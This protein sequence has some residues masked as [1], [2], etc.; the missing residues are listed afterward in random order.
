METPFFEDPQAKLLAK[1]TTVERN[2]V[3]VI[4]HNPRTDCYLCLDCK[5]YGWRTF[6]ISCVKDNEDKIDVAKRAI[7]D[8]SGYTDAGFI[9]IIAKTRVGCYSDDKNENSI[10]NDT[11][12]LFELNTEKQNNKKK[13]DTSECRYHWISKESVGLFI[14]LS[15][16]KYIWEQCQK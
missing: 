7:I 11:A 3:N 9:R 5:R 15:S 4:V 6:I 16:Q 1:Y 2:A 14:N 8:V 13:K 12:L 10:S